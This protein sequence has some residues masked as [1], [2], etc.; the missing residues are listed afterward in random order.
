M[1]RPLLLSDA[2]IRSLGEGEPVIRDDM[3]SALEVKACAV[4]LDGLHARGR[5]SAGGMGRGGRRDR[6]GRSDETIWAADVE[7]GL[8]LGLAPSFDDLRL[9]L[10][11]SAW[12]G[13]RAFELQLARYPGAPE[14]GGELGLGY[15]RHRD[16][17]AGSRRRR[18]TA[19]L[20]LNP[21]YAERDGGCLRVHPP[22]GSRD[23]QPLGGRLVFFL[24]DA[25][26]HEVLPSRAVRRAATAWYSG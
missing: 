7:A 14:E 6:R 18:A 1:L 22:S 23:I 17:L 13:L 9:D 21:S 19:I 25:L 2:E 16:A 3:L 4:D 11:A 24:S 20:Y 26:E 10:N 8:F 15:T 12:L 5:L